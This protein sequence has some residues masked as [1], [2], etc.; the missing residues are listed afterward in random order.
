MEIRSAAVIGAGVMGSQIAAHLANAGIEVR[1]LDLVP[2]GASDR[3]V[4][5]KRALARLERMDPPALMSRRFLRRITPGNVEDDLEKLAEAD[6]ILEAVVERLEVKRELYGRIRE[7]MRPDAIV[8]SNTSTIPLR[9]LVEGLPDAFA[10][11][12]A[13]THFFN[14]PRYMRLLELVAGPRTDAEVIRTLA[15]FCDHRLGKSVVFAADTPG[16]VANRIGAFWIQ[17]SLKFALALGLSVEEADAVIGRPLGFPKT[18]IFGLIDLVGLDLLPYVDESLARALPPED[19]YHRVRAEFPLLGRL[20]AA[21]YTGRKGKGGFYRRREVEGR[22]IREVVDLES[23]E[24][25]PL[26]RVAFE[27]LELSKSGDLALLLEHEDRAGRYARAVLTRTLAYAAR[28]VP[29]IAE[30]IEAVDR[31]LRTGYG[32]RWGPF[33]LADRI[34]AARLLRL[35]E[36]EGVEIPPLLRKAAEGEGFYRVREGRLEQLTPDGPYRPVRRPAGVL[37]LEDVRRAAAP[38][39]KN[40]SASLWDLGDGV[41]GLEVHT[42][43]NTIDPDVLEIM[44]RALEIVPGRFRALVLYNEGEHFSAGANI[45]LALFA[46]NVGAWSL[47]EELVERGQRIY[48]ALRAAPFPVVAAPSGLALGGGCELLLAAD[49]VVAHAESYLGLVECGVGLVPAWGGCARLM[50]R[51]AADPRLPKGPMPPVMRAFETIGLA[52]VAKSAF[53]AR[54]LGFLSE[55]DEIVMNRDRLLAA[56]KAKALALAEDYRPPGP[57]HLALPGPTG[58]AALAMALRDLELRGR[59]TPHDRVVADALAEVLTGGDEADFV[60]PLDEA[61]VMARERAAFMR[62]IRT[63][64]TLERMEHTLETGRPLRN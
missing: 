23:G 54:E 22:R 62:L 10:R 51:Y 4:I 64:P 3:S 7:V 16:F 56:A 52:R 40:G 45:A 30:E 12:F 28:L 49:R 26:R 60:D 59:L 61:S 44:A 27:S 58:K 33:E 13:I 38:V 25:R 36:R 29:A 20:V 37:L 48:S 47:I 5:A 53:E 24:F 41:L 19:P 18:G 17:A 2:E 35:C 46:A 39:A 50:A 57:A 15:D 34:G 9:L 63:E 43:M 55:E 1:L 6:W 42:R 32:W 14:P 8:T 21:G 11:R 31:A